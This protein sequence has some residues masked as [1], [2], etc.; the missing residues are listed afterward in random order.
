MARPYDWYPLT[1]SDPVPGAPSVLE[2]GAELYRRIGSSASRAYDGLDKLRKSADMQ[3][4]AVAALRDRADEVAKN[5][6]KVGTRYGAVA[7]ALGNYAD[8][9]RR[10]QAAADE[11]LA[12]ARSVQSLR[13]SH[14]QQ[15]HS[16]LRL[17]DNSAAAGDADAAARYA[18]LAADEHTEVRR[19]DLR[20]AALRSDDLPRTTRQRDAAVDAL[21]AELGRAYDDGLSDGWWEDWGSSLCSVVSQWA[22]S[23]ATWVG[24]AALLLCWVPVLGELL[25]AI[26]LIAGAIALVADVFLALHGEQEWSAVVWG[27]VALA[28]FGVG[29]VAVRGLRMASATARLGNGVSRLGVMLRVTAVSDDAIRAVGVE[30]EVGLSAGSRSSSFLR[31]VGEATV[32]ELKL[33]KPSTV[34][35]N[36]VDGVKGVPEALSRQNFVEGFQSLTHGNPVV[37]ALGS[38]LHVDG[39]DLA[40]VTNFSL[41]AEGL[42]APGFH[43]AE[44]TTTISTDL[45]T[46][47]GTGIVGLHGVADVGLTLQDMS[48]GIPDVVTFVDNSFRWITTGS[49]GE[50]AAQKLALP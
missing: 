17:Q 23:I 29:R 12:E 46:L 48:E 11:V 7:T 15:E 31:T 16:Y 3:S 44:A 35:H 33:L 5:L 26:A 41:D 34:L 8:E 1:S 10:A 38:A 47:I 43:F 25:G 2:D 30:A 32:E 50:D 4:D 21:I 18:S 19:A 39:G 42:I 37:N 40:S 6:D 20:I 28:S 22:G 45:P 49:W 14:H 27:V 36:L 24:V 9:L 13:D